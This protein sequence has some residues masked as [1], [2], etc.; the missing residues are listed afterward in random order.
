MTPI[1]T[2]RQFLASLLFVAAASFSFAG[3]SEKDDANCA[4]SLNAT[5][6]VVGDQVYFNVYMLNETK[7][8]FYSLVK[9]GENEELISVGL[10]ECAPNKLNTPILYSFKD[11]NT[12]GKPTR[13][14]LVRINP[15]SKPDYLA[16]WTITAGEKESTVIEE[17]KEVA[18]SMRVL[19]V[20]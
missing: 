7:T 20:Y 4:P 13:Y 19:N 9:H 5:V 14:E 16:E 10:K 18:T 6:K 2:Y 8:G 12:T 1:A 15:T 11:V 17:K 3:G